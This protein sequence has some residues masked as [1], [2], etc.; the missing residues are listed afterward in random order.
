TGTHGLELVDGFGR[1]MIVAAVLAAGGGVLAFLTVRKAAPVRAVAR[2]DAAMP[3]YDCV[4]V[5]G[6]DSAYGK[7]AFTGA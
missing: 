1:A 4:R 6:T 2:A 5:D 7:R 3:C